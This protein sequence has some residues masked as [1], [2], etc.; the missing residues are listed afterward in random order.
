MD[1]AD[2]GDPLDQIERLD[3][4]ALLLLLDRPMVA[5][6]RPEQDCFFAWLPVA[7]AP[8]IV[9][10]LLSDVPVWLPLVLCAIAVVSPVVFLRQLRATMAIKAQIEAEANRARTILAGRGWRFEGDDAISPF[11][12]RYVPKVRGYHEQIDNEDGCPI[13]G[14]FV[15]TA[16]S[17]Q[18]VL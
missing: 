3:D 10:G 4:A 7:M 16:I 18:P 1:P 9:G 2:P 5:L 17:R 6:E 12:V 15:V 11:R 8:M 14:D 13:I